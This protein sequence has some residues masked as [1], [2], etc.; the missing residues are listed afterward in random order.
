MRK[1]EKLLQLD[2]DKPD[3]IWLEKQ[4][5]LRI[6]VGTLGMLL[7]LAIWLVVLIDSG[8]NTPLQSISH[9]YMSRAS[10]VFVLVMSLL[11]VFLLIYKGLELIDFILSSIAG[12]FALCVVLFP[13]GNLTDACP[14]PDHNS[15]IITLVKHNGFRE[16]FHFIS[17]GIFLVAL[18]AMSFFLFT[19]TESGKRKNMTRQKK[20]RNFIYRLAAIIIVASIIIIILGNTGV[21]DE[22]YFQSH[23]LTFWFETIAVE[24]FGVS[25][26]IKAEVMLK[27]Q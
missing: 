21:L 13:T 10:G 1:P 4:R 26:F 5:S 18:A 9:Y 25:W 11:A 3:N 12:I 15:V 7:P 6:L 27:D 22:K 20:I 8:E 23:H 19:K 16:T 24:A 14:D 17:A 2:Y